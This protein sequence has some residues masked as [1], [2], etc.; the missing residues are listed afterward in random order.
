MGCRR[1][2]CVQTVT[3]AEM[4]KREPGTR[5]QRSSSG[6]QLHGTG[7]VSRDCAPALGPV[8]MLPPCPLH[9]AHLYTISQDMFG[10]VSFRPMSSTSMCVAFRSAVFQSP[11]WPPLA[12]FVPLLALSC[13]RSACLLPVA[14]RWSGQST[15]SPGQKFPPLPQQCPLPRPVRGKGQRAAGTGLPHLVPF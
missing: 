6:V 9:Q 2:D 14:A 15:P 1:S 13:S 12:F 8:G 7:L 10:P 11:Q 5:D 4:L 3:G